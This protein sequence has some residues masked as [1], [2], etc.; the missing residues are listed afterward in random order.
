MTPLAE[1]TS[2]DGLILA[3]RAR[4]DQLNVSLATIDYVAGFP[5]RY[6]G[7]I[8]SLRGARRIGMQ[9]LGPLLGALG[10]K[11]IAVDDPE[12][13]AKIRRR[14]EPRDEAHTK[15]AKALWSGEPR[16]PTPRKR[17]AA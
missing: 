12:Q 14:L 5:D 13:L 6:S 16:S 3:L 10:L 8:L 2:Y 17:K 9:S 1:I 4:Q 15:S 7:K 11:L